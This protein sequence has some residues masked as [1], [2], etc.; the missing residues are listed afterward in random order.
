VTV[1]LEPAAGGEGRHVDGVV[2]RVEDTGEGIAP[3]HL[4]HLFERF[5]RADPGRA[6]TS[7]GAGLGLAI[8]EWVARV[9]GGRL[10]VTSAPGAGTSFTLWLPASPAPPAPRSSSTSASAA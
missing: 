8:C 6:R 1:S 4:P 10:T 9:H 2:I 5:Y 7:G 3:E